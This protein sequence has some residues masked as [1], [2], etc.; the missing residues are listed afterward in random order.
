MT[1]K[2]DDLIGK[3]TCADC[4]D[5]LKSLPDKSVDLILTDVPYK[6]DFE[7]G[8]GIRNHRPN[9]N[10]ISDY[11]ANAN[12]DF[13]VF[14]D[15]CIKKMNKVNFF[16]FCDKATK[17]DF[18]KLA[19]KYGYGYREIP[20][21]KTSPTPFANKQWL[22]DIEWGIHIF[23]RSPV[24]GD[25]TTKRGWFIVDNLREP[26]IE[27]PTPKRID[28]IQK[29]LLNLSQENQIVL[30]PFSGSGTTAVAC[31]NLKRRFIC[32]EKDPEYAEKSRE[33]L[34]QAQQQLNLF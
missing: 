11:G 13:T 32:I 19:E 16:T 17:F 3:I 12:I 8:G 6:M 18:L 31:H 29:L 28:I 9:Y 20:F 2:L 30:D 25:Y 26:N 15:L 27:H 5:V 4:M 1:Y 21:C 34:K 33:R 23:H 22:N 14:F 24:Y 10:K 7:H